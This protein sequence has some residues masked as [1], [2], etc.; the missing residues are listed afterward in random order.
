M[1]ETTNDMPPAEGVEASAPLEAGAPTQEKARGRRNLRTPFRRRRPA[2]EAAP[3][4][5]APADA[6]A[7]EGEQAALFPADAKPQRR[8]PREAKGPRRPGAPGAPRARSRRNSSGAGARNAAR[9]VLRARP[10]GPSWRCPI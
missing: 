4:A 7:A 6:P 10:R 5:G 1:N 8:K 3:E 2:D 9:R